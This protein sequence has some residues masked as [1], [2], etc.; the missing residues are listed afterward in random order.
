MST[1]TMR[2]DARRRSA[3][4]IDWG[5]VAVWFLGFGLVTYL[6]LK[7][8]GYDSIV[9]DEVG[10]AAWWL[11]LLAV[12][13]GALP[14]GRIGSLAWVALAVLA[15]FTA[16]TALS[17]T[18]TESVERT[19]ADLARVAGYLG[20]FAF[21][22]FAAR[23]KDARSLVGAVASAITLIAAIALLSRFQPA[24]FPGANETAT[25]LTGNRERLSYPLHYWNGVAALIAIGLP[26][27]LQAACGA[28]SLWLR[29][30]A[31]AALPALGLTIFLTLSRGGMI[32]AALALAAFV[33][34][35]R[36]RLAK[37]SALIVAALAGAILLLAV[38]ARDALQDGLVNAT[39]ESQGDAMMWITLVVCLLAGLAHVGLT[40]GLRGV[41]RPSLPRMT[42]NRALAGCAV[43]ALAVLLAAAAFD[44]PGRASDAW[45]EFKRSEGPGEG[46]GRLSSTAGQ[47]RYQLWSA[48]VKQNAE[49]PLA[50]TGSGTFEYWWART[51]DVPE[52]VRD[53]H[54]LYFQTLGELGI[55]GLA[56]IVALIATTLLGGTRLVLR[57]AGP[58]RSALAAALAGCLAF[59]L[60]AASDWTWQIPVLP[61]A[62]LLLVAFLLAAPGERTGRGFPLWPRLGIVLAAVAAIVAI[63]IPLSSTNYLRES[64]RHFRE[65]D[66]VAALGDARS[67]QN[68]EPGAATPRLQEALVLEAAGQFGEAAA[69]A[70][71]ATEK[72][73]TNWRTW[74]ILSRLEAES[75]NAAASVQAYNRARSLN[76][77][78]SI[79]DR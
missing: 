41:G 79:F 54:S 59:F 21:A 34:L 19:A 6:G 29:G 70:E 30:A 58:G 64:E 18:W 69:V 27:V 78:S 33:A 53:A 24:W 10:I 40:I 47:N 26:L 11:V 67:A 76:P 37:L 56:L 5:V 73:P 25:F 52:V 35:D 72:E 23:R 43:A 12:G 1:A 60:T 61:V 55:V 51:G 63:A 44:V 68:V 38:D 20:V 14:R 36:D 45:A 75:G 28:R 9:H 17:L 74:L 8:G 7:G 65:G 57:E 50:G 16:W 66:L 13:V 3:H 71:T 49:R 31:A 77:L 46:A 22:V 15:A 39:A 48:A 2:P 32:A 62:M 4:E 42:R